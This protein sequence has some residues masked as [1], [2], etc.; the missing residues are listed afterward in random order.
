MKSQRPSRRPNFLSRTRRPSV[1]CLV[2]LLLPVAFVSSVSA[3]QTASRLTLQEAKAKYK[4]AKE[5]YSTARRLSAQGSVSQSRLRRAKFARDLAGLELSSLIDP[6]LKS[7][8]KLLRARVV[9]RFRNQEW[10]IAQRL[11][12]KGSIS[13]LGWRRAQTAKDVAKLE[14]QALQGSS[15]VQRQLKQIKASGLRLEAAREE[16]GTAKRLFTVGSIS[17][18]EFRQI[19]ERLEQV[20]EA[21]R[22]SKRSFGVRA[23]PIRT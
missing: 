5:A 10:E 22:D 8:N 1:I 2:G 12:K 4:E 3:C 9:Y 19:T 17:A 11:Y 15:K 18:E 13:E 6:S 7:Y 14:L 20:E 16:Y 23:I 21:H